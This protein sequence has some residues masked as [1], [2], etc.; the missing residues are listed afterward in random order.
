VKRKDETRILTEQAFWKVLA[1]GTVP[2]VDRINTW[3]NANGHGSR[4]RTVINAELKL[5]WEELGKRSRGSFA[6]PGVSE[7]ATAL[8]QKLCEDLQA[9]ARA[10]LHVEREEILASAAAEIQAAQRQVREAEQETERARSAQRESVA[11]FDALSADR[12][13]MRSELDESRQSHEREI[14]RLQDLLGQA[15][16]EAASL[17]AQLDAEGNA[18]IAEHEA[19]T[20]EQRRQALEIDGL[21]TENKAYAV[22]EYKLQADLDAS[23]TREREMADRAR[24]MS[25]EMGTL[26]GSERALQQQV[27]DLQAAVG[28]RDD[29][30]ALVR[31]QLEVAREQGRARD[32]ELARARDA[33]AASLPLN[34]EQLV[35]LIAQGWAAGAVSPGKAV[36][37]SDDE[38][39]VYAERGGRYARRALKAAGI[40]VPATR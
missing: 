28:Q 5:C 20:R 13:R 34:P 22:R 15:K 16:Q 29:E 33:L 25:A 9:S 32:D 24:D 2:T 3:L 23:L 11:A 39:A 38:Q 10:D 37:A 36:P 19:A 6:L 4:D 30:I 8:F 27:K 26:R 21:R 40:K 12:E 17:R 18:R 14:A 31:G 35:E 7:G 1:D